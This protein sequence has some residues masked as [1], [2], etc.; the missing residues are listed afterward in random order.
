MKQKI[1]INKELSLT[2]VLEYWAQCNKTGFQSSVESNQTNTL[3]LVL[4]LLRFEMADE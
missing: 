1:T 2:I 3:V 4:F